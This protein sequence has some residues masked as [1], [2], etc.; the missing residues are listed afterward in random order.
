MPI[1]IWLNRNFA[2]SVHL[3]RQLRAN[4][5][6]TPVDILASHPD[7]SSPTLIGVDEVLPEPDP[8]EPDF[9]DRMLA[10]CRR[11]GVDVLLPVA[12]QERIAARLADFAAAGVAVICPPA[13]AIEV[14]ADKAATYRSI[15]DLACVPPWRSVTTV[16]EFDDACAELG[17]SL[18][19]KP[20]R[21]VGA[22]G[23]RFLVESEPVL[24]DL[25][26]PVQATITRSSFRRALAAAT[27]IPELIV[28][29]YLSGPETSVD[30]LADHGTLV[31]AVP[32]GKQGRW[33]TLDGDPRLMPLTREL[34]QRFE[35]DGL[36][37]VQFRFLGGEPMLLEINT[38]PAGGLFQTELSG[39]NLV[40]GAVRQ[41]LGLPAELAEP[42]LGERFVTVPALF[43][44]D[45]V[46]R[47]ANSSRTL[48]TTSLMNDS[49][50]ASA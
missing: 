48:S 41:A 38:R 47:P 21:G 39:V 46:Q 7:P 35:L 45:Q 25:L 19:I 17:H 24:A 4:P 20:A 23:V 12:G 16:A 50:A 8:A 27:E 26:G 37:N 28:M 6:G 15:A 13:A 10:L 34:V 5:D 30:V 49:T 2:T 42:V 9:A 22:Q 14:L 1:R 32:R 11:H 31:S 29:P 33:R 40:W 18:V 36:V 43:V 44:A 3:H